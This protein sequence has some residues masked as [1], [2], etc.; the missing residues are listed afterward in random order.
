MSLLRGYDSAYPVQDPPVW[1]VCLFYMGGTVS[2]PDPTPH[3]WSDAEIMAQPV[4]YLDPTWVVRL[5]PALDTADQGLLDAAVVCQWLRAHNVPAGSLM[6]LD[7]ETLV[8]PQYVAAFDH[9]IVAGGYKCKNYGSIAYVTSNPLTSGGRHSADWRD[10]PNLDP[11]AGVVATQ[12]ANATQLGTGYDASV[13]ESG[14]SLWRKPTLAPPP[15]PVTVALPLVTE[16]QSGHAVAAV[17]VLC[18]L[19]GHFPANSGTMEHPDG[20]FGSGTLAAVQAVQEDA[21]RT[22]PAVTTEGEV[23]VQTWGI[24]LTGKPE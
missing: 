11:A 17:Q 23:G 14:L 4:T 5:N 22:F 18:G 16:G 6:T 2:D 15:P 24:F 10:I 12:F 19:L 21:H 7:T 20:Q 8:L 9:G 3:G 13:Y 1:D